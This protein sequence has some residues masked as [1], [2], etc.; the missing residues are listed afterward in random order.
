MRGILH[1]NGSIP[2]GMLVALGLTG[3]AN[4]GDDDLV[5]VACAPHGPHRTHPESARDA[6]F[7]AFCGD[8]SHS[9]PTL[10]FQV[11][12]S[13]TADLNGDG[14]VEFLAADHLRPAFG[15]FVNAPSRRSTRIFAQGVRVP[16]DHGDN[17]AG[18]VTADFDG[19]GKLDV[20]NSNHPGTLTVRLNATRDGASRLSFPVSGETDVD[21]GVDYGPGFGIAGQEGGLVVGDWNGD[22]RPDLA[23]ADLGRTKRAQAGRTKA[24]PTGD[25]VA[26]L[27][28]T[29]VLLN[30]TAPGAAKASFAPIVYFPIPGP[31]ISLASA[32]FD[33]DGRPDL[34]TANT[35]DSSLSV[36]M[37]Q[38]EPGVD[39]PC[40][41]AATT[42]PIPRHGLRQG[43][44]PT[45]AVI[46]DVD[47]D[48]RPD[49]ASANWNTRTISVF[50]NTTTGRTPSFAPPYELST[51]D[52]PPLVLRPGD[53]DRDGRPDL[54]V[55]PLSTHSNAAML[56]VRNET[57]GE[58]VALAIDAVYAIPAQLEN[59][60][61]HEYF[62]SAGMVDDF[63][64]DGR[65][66]IGVLIARGSLLLKL[67]SPGDDVLKFVDPGVPLWVVHPILPDHSMLVVYRQDED[68]FV[69]TP[70]RT[71][72]ARSPRDAGRSPFCG[73][74][75]STLAALSDEVLDL[76][77]AGREAG[78]S[79]AR[80]RAGQTE[81]AAERL[82]A[83]TEQAP[84]SVRADLARMTAF[85]DD[86]GDTMLT[87]PSLH[88]DHDVEHAVQRVSRYLL[89][90]CGD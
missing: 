84:R 66:D 43:A 85:V 49:I 9:I 83:L 30:T 21:L 44:G 52:L 12:D 35:G 61:L 55:I 31:A 47:A 41:S 74:A 3:C 58:E 16:F 7:P 79:N 76:A 77:D 56:V 81:H 32:D 19:D 71:A 25:P 15:Y 64:G 70:R 24:C 51:G 22:G 37:N 27:H 17:S 88:V 18:I 72:T 48:G 33:G 87:A 54:V 50:R 40:F 63:D 11:C 29:A 59:R 4:P 80:I 78:H 69:A 13:T 60:W 39:A 53:L 86:V 38:T 26:S 57:R 23:T 67:M 75:R 68:G 73:E 1:T 34:V 36:L 14:R 10:P 8:V 46:L 2:I 90:T 89:E 20:A 28:T 42:L 6:S 82:A 62:S 5:D 45:H 65:L